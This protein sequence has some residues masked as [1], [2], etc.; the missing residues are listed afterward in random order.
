MPDRRAP[1]RQRLAR[2]FTRVE[3]QQQAFA[4]RL[5]ARLFERDP[6]VERWFRETGMDM[7][8]L[9]VIQALA[10][11]AKSLDARSDFQA[12]FG[13]LGRRHATYGVE[14]E[15]FPLIGAAFADTCR[16]ILGAEFDADSERELADLFERI[17]TAM[18][19]GAKAPRAGTD[20]F[21]TRPRPADAPC[22]PYLERFIG[23]R[24][25]RSKIIALPSADAVAK[26][27]TIDYLGEKSVNAPPMQTILETSCANGIAHVSECGGRARCSTCRVMIVEGLENC[28]PRNTL[29]ERLAAR[30]GF[31]PEIRLACQ[32]RVMGDVTL[33]RL[34][35]D[36][37]DIEMALAD[38]VGDAG[39]EIMGA[40][41]FT[42]L[43]GFTGFAESH[44]P[45]DVIHA[46]NLLFGRLGRAV[47]EHD[48]YVDK[49]IG[50]NLMALFGLRGE[51]AEQTCRNA[52][53]AARDMLAGLPAV[54]R[55]LADYL[56]GE[57]RL[58]IGIAYG[59]M[60]TGELGFPL[61]RQF[62]A[63]GDTVN[64]AARLES[65]TRETQA[66]LL[67]SDSVVQ[68]LSPQAFELVSSHELS[69][70][71]KTGTVLAHE[72]VVRD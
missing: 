46:L 48:G 61:K 54:N 49:Y 24:A 8:G 38:S 64:I 19:A 39:E 34:V 67:V 20:R 27:I 18:R 47:N 21:E 40:V 70:K 2:L 69:L 55:Y 52:V 7:Q 11:G 56:G 25:R 37:T 53:R 62:T 12:V 72:I 5:Y 36:E 58:G 23:H 68:H 51:S 28:M 43:W 10:F 65:S 4:G 44:L 60:V 30:K 9:M 59:P 42:D 63:I 41:L 14:P 57:F 50:D 16:D 26:R 32:T 13:D 3:V 33:K 66:D 35:R 22:D 31:Y 29:E 6:D 1:D 15:L 71:G 45:Y 17:E